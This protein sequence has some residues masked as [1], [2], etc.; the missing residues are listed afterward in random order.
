VPAL[1]DRLLLLDGKP[2]FRVAKAIY[3]TQSDVRHVQFAK[4]ALRAGIELLLKHAGRAADQVDEVIIA[5]SFGYHLQVDSLA[6]LGLLPAVLSDRV[7]FVGNTSR[8][9]AEAF[10]LNTKARHHV[11][12]LVARV[13]VV[14]LADDARFQ[15]VF[16]QSMGFG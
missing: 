2:A 3:L 8:T 7:R 14:E 9:G 16:V 10:L 13:N 5:G 12:E 4:G 15:A 1:E 6:R 11:H